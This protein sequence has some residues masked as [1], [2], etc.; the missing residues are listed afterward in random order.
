MKNA[1][2]YAIFALYCVSTSIG[3][4]EKPEMLTED[5]NATVARLRLLQFSGTLES[6]DMAFVTDSVTNG[7]KDLIRSAALCAA[8]VHRVNNLNDIVAR[9]STSNAGYSSILCKRVLAEVK[10]G[11]DPLESL[12]TSNQI[13]NDRT[14]IGI[15]VKQKASLIWATSKARDLRNGTTNNVVTNNVALT[16]Y[17]HK[18]LY[19]SILPEKEGFFAVFGGIRTGVGGASQP[20]NR[21]W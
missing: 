21:A 7:K 15:L 11:R 6:R 10:K 19:Y 2:L 5:D 8:I 20:R 17:D 13:T 12:V 1:A 3:F 16:S 18:L 4:C 9:C 14:A